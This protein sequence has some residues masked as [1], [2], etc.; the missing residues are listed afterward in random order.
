MAD[1]SCPE[2][3]D[4]SHRESRS[5]IDQ[6]PMKPDSAVAYVL[7]FAPCEGRLLDLSDA[8]IR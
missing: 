1:D 4:R 8:S 5:Y 2:F 7:V 3:I 6:I